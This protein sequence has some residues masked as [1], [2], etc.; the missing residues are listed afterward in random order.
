M[1]TSW[2]GDGKPGFA[3][4]QN[5]D[6]SIRNPTRDAYDHAFVVLALAW[7]LRASGAPRVETALK[8][9]LAFIDGYLT[10]PQGALYEDDLRT[11]PRR[12]NPQMHWFEAML[13]LAGAL[14][15]PE[16]HARAARGLALFQS[17]LFNPKSGAL[18]EYYDDSWAPAPGADG[19][20][21]EPGHLAEWSWLLRQ[22]GPLLNFDAAPVADILLDTAFP[23][24]APE[25]GLLWDEVTEAGAVRLRSSRSWPMT[26]LAKACLAKAEAGDA[27]AR[28]KALEA[29]ERLDRYFLRKPFPAGWLDRVDETG[30]P[31]S[32]MVS[33]STLYHIFVAVSEADRVLGGR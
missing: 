33:A 12:Q 31:M 25:T 17:K 7:L 11:Q 27:L 4:S 23:L 19:D 8:Q 32:N 22:A 10:D 13:A 21:V 6:G 20:V 18:V 29:L 14:R 28:V 24:R 30:S 1:A 3:Q 2:G 5:A 16:A 26:E 9:T 15:H